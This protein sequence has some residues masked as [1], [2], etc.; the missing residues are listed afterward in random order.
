[1]HKLI[2]AATLATIVGV[3]LYQ[4][5]APTLEA[6]KDR[7]MFNKWLMQN[8]KAYGNDDEKE[9]RFQNFRDSVRQCDC[10]DNSDYELGLNEFADL[11][12]AEFIAQHTGYS[13]GMEST[14]EKEEDFEKVEDD[15]ELPSSIDWTTRG[16]VNP[17][18]NQGGCGSCWT[19]SGAAS[20]ESLHQNRT[21]KLLKF[22]EQALVDCGFEYGNNGCNGGLMMGA[23]RWSA[24][25]GMALRS[26]YPY[27]AREGTCKIA[28]KRTTRVNRSYKRVYRD[29]NTS[30]MS[31]ISQGV[32]S[33][34]IAAN[35]IK[36]YRGGV[37]TNWG[38]GTGLNH[39]VNAVGYGRDRR[40]GRNFWKVR[41]SWGSRW[42]EGGYIRM[43]RRS[44]GVGMCGLTLWPF[45]PT[46]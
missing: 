35:A 15:V 32:V 12:D 20:L 22:S 28:S 42:G 29:H 13:E 25:H 33:V 34:A 41:N 5:S 7:A 31:A 43:E 36:L 4:M 9:Y 11:S 26:D 40:T 37:F 1:M 3:S 44:S 2:V 19:F 24:D 45:Y 38:C 27:T 30:L 10:H 6:D 39:G 8:G 16:N 18:Q 21:G 23:F 46:A 17:V 14:D